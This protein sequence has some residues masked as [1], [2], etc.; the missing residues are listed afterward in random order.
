[1]TMQ[2]LTYQF[3]REKMKSLFRGVEEIVFSLDMKPLGQYIEQNLTHFSRPS[4]YLYNLIGFKL[5]HL[6]KG[7]ARVQQRSRI[8][9]SVLKS[10]S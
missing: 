9:V 7:P 2:C 5:P 6:L 3:E 4:Q 10:V 1:M 8:K